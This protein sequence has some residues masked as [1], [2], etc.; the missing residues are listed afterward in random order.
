ML[1]YIIP[2]II[3]VA[4][5]IA[6]SADLAVDRIPCADE[7]DETALSEVRA[8]AQTVWGE[9]RGLNEYEQSLIVWCILNRVDDERFPDDIMSVITAPSQFMGYSKHNPVSTIITETAQEICS[10]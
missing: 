5:C 9:G 1:R 10:V 2:Y 3:S 8:I 4:L 7:V 6:P